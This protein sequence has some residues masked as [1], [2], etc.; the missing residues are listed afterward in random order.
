M[1]NERPHTQKK[2]PAEADS[3]KFQIPAAYFDQ[4]TDPV[5]GFRL[6]S[7]KKEKKSRRIGF[8]TN[9][10][11]SELTNPAVYCSALL[12][13]C[14]VLSLVISHPHEQTHAH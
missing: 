12:L 11:R 6:C 8:V 1:A 3:I 5:D 9:G 13:A 10:N 2:I 4:W 7:F 14:A